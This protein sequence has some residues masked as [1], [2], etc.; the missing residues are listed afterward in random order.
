[1][2]LPATHSVTEGHN[3]P[4][5]GGNFS[6]PQA[7]P[8]SSATPSISSCS[9]VNSSFPNAILLGFSLINVEY[10]GLHLFLQPSSPEDYNSPVDDL[11]MEITEKLFAMDPQGKSSYSQ[12]VDASERFFKCVESFQHISGYKS[13]DME[14]CN[15]IGSLHSCVYTV[16]VLLHTYEN[17]V[18]QIFQSKVW[19]LD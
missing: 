1:M 14:G 8:T 15:L 19:P 18:T 6:I 10:L 7:P 16:Y 9:T 2:H 12:E 3:M 11:K 5:I 17:T 4:K 13:Q